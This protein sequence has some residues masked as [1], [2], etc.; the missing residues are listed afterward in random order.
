MIISYDA[1]ISCFF[2]QD[3]DGNWLLPEKRINFAENEGKRFAITAQA[4]GKKLVCP[5]QW[6]D[7]A[8]ILQDDGKRGSVFEVN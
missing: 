6:Q 5:V 4:A 7:I 1:L 2:D 3:Q 8:Y